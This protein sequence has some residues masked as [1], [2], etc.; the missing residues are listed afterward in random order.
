[1]R[2]RHVPAYFCEKE[3]RKEIAGLMEVT[4]CRAVDADGMEAMRA[5]TDWKRAGNVTPA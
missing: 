2:N 3:H 5:G 1:M 4:T